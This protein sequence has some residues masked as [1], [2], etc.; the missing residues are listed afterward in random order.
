VTRYA[1]ATGGTDPAIL[2][3]AINQAAGTITPWFE[4]P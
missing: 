4:I 2:A 3:V 1:P